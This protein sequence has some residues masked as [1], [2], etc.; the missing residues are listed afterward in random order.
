VVVNEALQTRDLLRGC[1]DEIPVELVGDIDFEKRINKSVALADDMYQ[2]LVNKKSE[3]VEDRYKELKSSC[4][5]C[6]RKYR[7]E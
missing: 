4:V 6:H 1:A 3:A 2:A 7:N 5:Y